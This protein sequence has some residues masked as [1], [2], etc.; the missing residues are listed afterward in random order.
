MRALYAGLFT[1]ALTACVTSSPYGLSSSIFYNPEEL[2]VQSRS[3][4]SMDTKTSEKSYLAL[5]LPL[6]AFEKMRHDVETKEKVTLKH[7]SEAHITVIT[8]P[9]FKE[10]KKHISMAE[11]EALADSMGL[12]KASYNLLCVG[13]GTSQKKATYFVVVQSEDLFKIRKAIEILYKEKGGTDSGFKAEEYH[14]H[15]TLGFTEKD[16]HAQDGVM[17]DASS[18]LYSLQPGVKN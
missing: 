4:A 2:K 3:I 12:K 5:D 18:C 10:L 17:K 6:P 9:E 11:I 8:P 13:K 15:V 16:L 14:P 7:R 1:L